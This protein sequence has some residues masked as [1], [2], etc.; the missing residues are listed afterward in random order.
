MRKR[1][2]TAFLVASCLL[3]II[4]C[5]KKESTQTD[6][7]GQQIQ[8]DNTLGFVDNIE[9]PQPDFLASYQP[10]TIAQ[11]LKKEGPKPQKFKAC[12]DDAISITCAGGT[13]LQFSPSSF[14]Y[15]D[16][17]LPVNGEVEIAVTE[18]LT[19]ADIL[20]AGLQTMAGKEFIETGGMLYVDAAAG[21]RKCALKFGE[22]YSVEIPTDQNKDGMQL[23]YGDPDPITNVVNWQA[24]NG[25][26]NAIENA[27]LKLKNRAPAPQFE[28]GLMGL[29]TYLNQNVELPEWARQQSLLAYKNIE[30]VFNPDGEVMKVIPL[31]KTTTYADSQIVEA[32]KYS[33]CWLMPEMNSNE[34]RRLRLPVKLNWVRDPEEIPLALQLK[35]KAE[36]ANYTAYFYMDTYLMSAGQL[37]WINCDRFTNL[38]QPLVDMFIEMS[39]ELED[40]KVELVFKDIRGYLHGMKY[41]NGY[42]FSNVPANQEATIVAMKLAGTKMK[43]AVLPCT[44]S[45]KDITNLEFKVVEPLEAKQILNQIGDI[46]NR[47]TASL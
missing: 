33:P 16:T 32:L 40:M 9:P 17:K 42:L 21:G 26:A 23:F 20:F 43:M 10:L 30:M 8:S 46:D 6:I 3:T 11:K 18:Y 27:D 35:D 45:D 41:D 36:S 37:G 4:S 34:I 15:A 28:G 12:A 44:T 29:Y 25:A 38:N 24:A 5:A 39:T 1:L 14:V 31:E 19:D 2:F 47:Q 13:K 7:V 22:L